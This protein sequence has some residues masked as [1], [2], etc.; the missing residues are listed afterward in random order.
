MLALP[1]SSFLWV[2][3]PLYP[4][5]L[6]TVILVAG[7]TLGGMV[8]YFFARTMATPWF[9]PMEN[10]RFFHLLEKRSD[11]LTQCMLRTFPGFP[12]SFINYSAGILKLPLL[13]F[14]LAAVIGLS[15]KTMLYT[16]TI[17]RAMKVTNPADLIRIETMVPL[18][19]LTLF[20]ALAQLFQRHLSRTDKKDRT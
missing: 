10:N 13:P 7:S 16:I 11:F 3:A 14:L 4:P 8:A 20:F 12:H 19:M 2:A 1:G 5:L 18:L 6:A 9:A 17:H 15:I